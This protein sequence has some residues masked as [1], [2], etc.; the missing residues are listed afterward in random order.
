MKKIALLRK[1][2]R[3]SDTEQASA[4]LEYLRSHVDGTEIVEIMY[5]NLVFSVVDRE[6]HVKDVVSGYDLADFDFVYAKSWRRYDEV[7]H[8]IGMYLSKKQV[9]MAPSAFMDI[10]AHSKLTQ[11]FAFWSAEIPTP[12]TFF[13]PRGTHIEAV[14]GFAQDASGQKVVVKAIDGGQGSDN[15]VVESPEAARAI[16]T[17]APSLEFIVQRFIPNECDYRLIVL[18]GE[19]KLIIKRQR[20]ANSGSHLNNTS[21]GAAATVVAIED[22]EREYLEIAEKTAKVL[23]REVVGIDLL[24]SDDGSPRVLEINDGLQIASGSAIEQKFAIMAEFLNNI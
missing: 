6:A 23:K 1:G 13:T 3:Q 12:D 7:L 17:Q 4:Y 19:V 10:F 21:Q 9:A 11:A 8:A 2:G 14:V 18:G 5:D 22:F 15:Y 24:I 16:I 20:A